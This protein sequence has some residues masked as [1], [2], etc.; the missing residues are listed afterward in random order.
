MSVKTCVLTASLFVSATSA[1]FANELRAYTKDKAFDELTAAEHAAAKAEA[2]N[3]KLPFVR[4]CADPGNMPQSNNKSEGYQNKIIKILVEDIGG[5]V[6]FFWRPYHERGLTRETF[7]NDE[8]DLLLDMPVALQ[9]LLTTEPI[10]RTTYVLAYRN[11]RGYAFEDLDDPALKKLKVGVFQHS[12]I[13]EALH[14]RGY[15]DLTLHVISY[16]SDLVPEN[17]PWHQVQDVIDGK[18]DVAA[19]W[20]PFAGWLPKMKN[21]PLTIQPVNLMDDSVPLEFDL[22]IGMKPNNV[23]LK[24][25]LDWALQRK[26]KEVEAVLRDYGVPLVKC[27]KCTVE[28]DIPARGSIYQRLRNVS[29]GRYLEQAEPMKLNDQATADQIVSKERME[30][31][32]KDGADPTLELIN[33]VNANSVERVGF[34]L[35]K[36]ADPNAQDSQGY[37]ALHHAARNRYSPLVALLVERGAD[38]NARDTDGFTPLL[39][40][41][42]RNHVPT[43]EMLIKNGADPELPTM[44][45]IRPLTWAIGD[46]K[47]FAAKALVDGGANVDSESG[48]ENVTPLMT[49]ATQITAQSSTGRVT[50]GPAPTDLASLLIAKG[51]NVNH[52]SK[53]GVTALMVAAGHNNAPMIGLLANAGADP[54]LKSIEGVTALQIAERAQNEHAIG[55]LKFLTS[56]AVT[57]TAPADKP[58]PDAPFQN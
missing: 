35:D 55:A 47:Y 34:M 51:A 45:G 12:G 50:Q 44:Q 46:G 10:Y 36:K 54:T 40:A 1:S 48:K 5:T 11:D 43:I 27:S 41:I 30:N 42:N 31:W 18:I 9:S 52:R 38:P 20:G 21:A 58:N 29:Q 22:A 19:V 6:D 16:N 49:V 37:S 3:R 15:K 39:H 13:R 7:Q 56:P 28:G 25:M 24:Y 57:Q 2:R 17:Q 4:V 53:E 26:A 8:C 32:L 33:A 23:L 14:R